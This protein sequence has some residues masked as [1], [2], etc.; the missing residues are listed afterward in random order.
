MK[1][2]LKDRGYP[3]RVI[4]EQVQ[5]AID[6]PRSEALALHRKDDQK[7][8]DRIPFV[9][10]TY[11]PSHSTNASTI[12]KYLPILHSSQRCKESIP[13]PPM[14]AFH[15]LKHIK[16]MVV[17]SIIKPTP[18][19]DRPSG[20]NPCNKCAACN[21]KHSSGTVQHTT[22]SQYFSSQVTGEKYHIHQSLNCYP[23]NIVYFSS[24]AKNV[25]SSMLEKQNVPLKP[26]SWNTVLIP[27]T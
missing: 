21:H 26:V 15:C 11:D 2:Y 23:T 25:V 12:H 19:D 16:D 20:F 10:I 6:I 13:K 4:E 3:D 14:V 7:N 17:R 27:N 1:Q 18:D 9:M 22:T 8:E 5:K 24:A